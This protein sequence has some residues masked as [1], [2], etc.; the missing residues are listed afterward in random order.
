MYNH[1]F[2]PVPSRRLG[3][4]LGVD[5]VPYKVCSF[6]CVYC[7]CGATTN[8]TLC[9]KE[10]VSCDEV[11][12]EVKDYLQ[13]NPPPD[14]ITFSGSGEPT[15]N[16][17]IGKI[18]RF[19]KSEFPDIRVAVLTNGSLLNDLDVRKDLLKAD[20]VLPSLDSASEDSFKKINRPIEELYLNDYIQGLV[21]F[22][23][24]YSGEIWLEI[25]ILPEYNDNS[26]DLKLLYD[27][28]I[29]IN[30]DIIQLNTLDRPGV[31]KGLKVAS[32]NYLKSIKDL[33]GL[34]NIEIIASSLERRK[35]K[36]YSGDIEDLILKTISRRPCTGNDLAVILGIHVNEVNKYLSTLE[37][38]KKIVSCIEERGV[39]YKKR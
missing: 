17:G 32:Y 35:V 36:S 6:D 23:K 26:N 11:I 14:Y 25:M 8:L 15:L 20:V 16:I 5:I 29:R 33:W 18:I 4:S 22:R 7:E 13:N 21:D 12:C 10:Y 30:P 27:A 31:V 24:E 38:E 39:F 37:A 1:L 9:R 19:I 3:M 28:I 2:G 34:D